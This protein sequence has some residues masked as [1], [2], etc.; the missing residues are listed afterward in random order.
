LRY[1]LPTNPAGNRVE[2]CVVRIHIS[3]NMSSANAI[4]A[5]ALHI[6][7]AR[8]AFVITIAQRAGFF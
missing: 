5:R 1:I 2:N 3:M 6:D 4:R 8:C 7:P